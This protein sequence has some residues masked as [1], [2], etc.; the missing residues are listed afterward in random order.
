MEFKSFTYTADG[1]EFD[2]EVV[3]SE[4]EPRQKELNEILAKTET[5]IE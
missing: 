2:V 4:I 1:F 5:T 3:W